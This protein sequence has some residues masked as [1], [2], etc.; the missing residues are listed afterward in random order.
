MT[1]MDWETLIGE[2]RPKR[3]NKQM[4]NIEKILVEDIEKE[5]ETLKQFKPNI[6]KIVEE[7]QYKIERA[8]AKEAKS[9]FTVKYGWS[10]VIEALNEA[11]EIVKKYGGGNV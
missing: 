6:D 10:C 11:I 7:L 5:I 8:S 1:T 4:E 2:N 3:G 9:E